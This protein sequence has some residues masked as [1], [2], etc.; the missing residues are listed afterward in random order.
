MVDCTVEQLLANSW[1][2]PVHIC[3]NA[4]TLLPYK[5]DLLFIVQ[6][7]CF[8]GEVLCSDVLISQA[9]QN[10]DKR[11]STKQRWICSTNRWHDRVC[12][13]SDKRE[14]S[15][16]VASQCTRG[17]RHILLYTLHLLF[18]LVP[19]AQRSVSLLLPDCF[20]QP[21][22]NSLCQDLPSSMPCNIS[23]ANFPAIHHILTS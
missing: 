7:F 16:F 3:A 9:E 2:A 21:Q 20:W 1:A 5:G 17:F 13:Q 14:Y 10:T 12:E 6:M 11:R 23:L 18:S 15:P 19:F 8:G 4:S 22:Y